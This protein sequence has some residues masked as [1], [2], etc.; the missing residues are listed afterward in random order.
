[1]T[2]QFANYFRLLGGKATKRCPCTLPEAYRPLDPLFEHFVAPLKLSDPALPPSNRLLFD[3]DC[4]RK[5]EEASFKDFCGWLRRLTQN[6]VKPQQIKKLCDK[7][8]T[9]RKN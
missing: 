5:L 4:F 6:E 8:E 1:M 3:L 7:I 2:S 9:R